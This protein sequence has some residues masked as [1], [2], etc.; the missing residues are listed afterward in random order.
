MLVSWQWGRNVHEAR[1][2]AGASSS[3][4]GRYL[5]LIAIQATPGSLGLD[6]SQV[7]QQIRCD[8]CLDAET[9]SVFRWPSP[10]SWA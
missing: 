2:V 3:L 1:S 8:T 10:R 6:L 9:A 4:A 5:G 7:L